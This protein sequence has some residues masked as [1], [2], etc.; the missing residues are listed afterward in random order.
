MDKRIKTK[1]TKQNTTHWDFSSSWGP[2]ISRS[3]LQRKYNLLINVLA[4]GTNTQKNKEKKERERKKERGIIKRM[5]G[6]A[7]NSRMPVYTISM[8]TECSGAKDHITDPVVSGSMW[9]ISKTSTSQYL[10][11]SHVEMRGKSKFRSMYSG[12]F[13]LFMYQ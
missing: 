6:I 12:F 13:L 11:P 1:K 8:P 5:K 4:G 9:I 2:A 3:P 10:L 7:V